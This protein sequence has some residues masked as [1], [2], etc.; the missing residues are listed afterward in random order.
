MM[1]NNYP[2]QN[3]N[4]YG[5]NMGYQYVNKPQ[6]KQT[7][8]LTQEQITKLR[9]SGDEF[10]WRV[11]QEQ[12]WRAICTHKDKNGNSSLVQDGDGLFH[13]TICG[14]AFHMF[15][16]NEDDV[17]AVVNQLMDILETTKAIYLDAPEQFAS[18]YY[19]FIPLIEK[20]PKLWGKAVRNFSQYDGAQ[21]VAPTNVYQFNPWAALNNITGGAGTFGG[22]P[23]YGQQQPMG[24]QQAPAG[25]P[26]QPMT[27]YQQQPMG[28]Q[29]MGYQAPNMPMDTNPFVNNMPNPYTMQAP[30]P[31]MI[32]QM[33]QMPIQQQACAPQGMPGEQPIPQNGE[34]VQQTAFNV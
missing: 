8:P 29:Q 22:M 32:P 14:K 33:P 24:Y 34:V 21:A 25:Y 11:T 26:Q 12:L 18:A 10:D 19:Q 4:P 28:Y 17:A 2:Q 15:D 13:C 31:G 23:V 30:A 20:F 7:Q 1:N 27:G 5:Y 9:S 6:P 3:A 16:G